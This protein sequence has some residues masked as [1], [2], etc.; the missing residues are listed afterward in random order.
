VWLVLSGGGV[1]MVH[2]LQL[3]NSEVT[4]APASWVIAVGY[5]GVCSCVGGGGGGAKLDK[6][7]AWWGY[8][9]VGVV[10]FGVDV[11]VAINQVVGLGIEGA[12][13]M[14]LALLGVGV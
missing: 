8:V 5:V 13:E 2:V 12:C 1:E 14:V 4:Q 11:D 3:G 6:V 7:S 9:K 10:V